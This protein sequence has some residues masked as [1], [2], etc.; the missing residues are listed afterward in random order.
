MTDTEDDLG[1]LEPETEILAKTD[2]PLTINPTPRPYIKAQP[3]A[4]L[5]PTDTS[6]DSLLAVA[7]ARGASVEELDKLMT[8]KER[9]EAGEAE[10]AYTRA[11]TKFKADAPEIFKEKQVSYPNKDG[12]LTQYKHATL[13]NVAGVIASSLSEYG[14]AHHWKTALYR[15]EKGQVRDVEVTCI[16]THELNH[17][18]ST[19]LSGAPDT[20]GGKNAIQG[21]GSTV[22]YLERYTLLSLT[23]LAAIDTDDDGVAAGMEYVTEE[24]LEELR[25]L[26][27]RIPPKQWNETIFLKAMGKLENL[28]ALPAMQFEKAKRVL[29]KKAVGS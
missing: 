6:P 15:D 5:Q 16:I 8:L 21:V 27:E 12:T 2:E 11:M 14:L 17:K 25:A 26:I 4:V 3:P 10:K 13:G 22:T 28:E 23:G 20:S 29:E 19:T 7:V 1:P 18:E 24:Q 9:Y